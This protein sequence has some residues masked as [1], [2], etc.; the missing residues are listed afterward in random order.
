MTIPAVCNGRRL[1]RY[2]VL[3]AIFVLAFAGTDL[4][5][6]PPII[7]KESGSITVSAKTGERRWT[8]DWTMEPSQQN[9]RKTI[10]FTER[11]RGRISPYSGEVQWSI[12]AVWLA[13]P[14][15]QPLDFEKTVVSA[16]GMPVATE[17]KHFDF[18]KGAVLFERRLA[19]KRPESKTLSIPK[20]V[21]AVEGIAGILR[22]LTFDSGRDF[23]THL[24]SNEPRLY[25]VTLENRG[26]ERVKTPI[27]VFEA[28]KIELVPHLG[29]LNVV[30]PF[31]A[32]TF[33][34]FNA[35]SPHFWVRYTGPENGPGTPEIV[36]EL[37]RYQR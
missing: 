12:E 5:Q 8:A 4:L 6:A 15:L 26:K 10:R 16:A 28:Y 20:D 2:R 30:R 29:V 7:P 31:V 35:E 9:G 11:G 17:R 23:A 33:F 19:G 27:G 18:N 25:S 37:S 13:E 21:L 32:K 34:W 3:T 36:M 14:D 22:F 1:A 24:V